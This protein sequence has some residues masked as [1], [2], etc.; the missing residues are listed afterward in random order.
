MEWV[1]VFAILLSPVIA[2][3]VTQ[4]WNNRKESKRRRKF[5]FGTLM[6]TRAT[7]TNPKHV[8]ALNRID[9]EFYSK[10]NTYKKVLEAWKIYHDHLNDTNI[11][12]T[13]TQNEIKMWNDKCTELLTDLLYEMSQALGYGFDKV[14]LKRGH[15]YPVGL[16]QAVNE[17]DIVRRGFADI[18]TGKTVFPMTVYPPPQD[19]GENLAKENSSK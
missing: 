7:T 15:Y 2:V 5:L 10:K 12:K 18:F 9:I 6:A 3:Q 19:S 16:G 17:Q 8:E 1:N 11:N 13:K 14:L 4:W